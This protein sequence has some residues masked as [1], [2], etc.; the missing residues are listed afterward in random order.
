MGDPL[1]RSGGAVT[2]ED[3]GAGSDG[4]VILF[5]VASL[6]Q[7]DLMIAKTFVDAYMDLE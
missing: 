4:F 7:G 3:G 6:I 2:R 1:R 5:R